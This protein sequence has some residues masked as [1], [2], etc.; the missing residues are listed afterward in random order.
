MSLLK[1]YLTACKEHSKGKCK[2]IKSI[3]N[4]LQV[5][6]IYFRDEASGFFWLIFPSYSQSLLKMYLYQNLICLSRFVSN[7]IFVVHQTMRKL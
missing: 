4:I 2:D 6:K 3:E 1:D 7:N 5:F